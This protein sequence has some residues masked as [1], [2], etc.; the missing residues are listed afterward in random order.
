MIS[1]Q[2]LIMGLVEEMHM[3]HTGEVAAA[4]QAYLRFRMM[5]APTPVEDMYI[6]TAIANVP[7]KAASLK[8]P[9]PIVGPTSVGQ[10]FGQ[11]QCILNFQR[12]RIFN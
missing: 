5:F 6:D 7:R 3:Q 1:Q 12:L 11:L 2:P 4:A 10:L 9:N 8:G